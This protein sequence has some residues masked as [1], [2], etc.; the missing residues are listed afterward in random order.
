MLGRGLLEPLDA[1][2]AGL[3]G[4]STQLLLPAQAHVP[5]SNMSLLSSQLSQLPGCASC[6]CPAADGMLRAAHLCCA[7]FRRLSP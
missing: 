7:V 1:L 6:W 4:L 3:Y 5:C 2:L